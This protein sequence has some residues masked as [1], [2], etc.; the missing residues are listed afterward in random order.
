M[1]LC[2]FEGSL[3][4][5]VS[6]R[7]G[8]KATE[9]PCLEKPKPKTKQNQSKTSFRPTAPEVSA[10]SRVTQELSQIRNVPYLAIGKSMGGHF[11]SMTCHSVKAR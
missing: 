7:I 9:K 10:G 11:W 1:D 8:S 3:I 5:R 6:S 4:Y 2:E